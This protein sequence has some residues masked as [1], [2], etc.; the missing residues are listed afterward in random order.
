M[1]KINAIILIQLLCIFNFVLKAQTPNFYGL[2]TTGGGGNGSVFRT[3]TTGN[4]FELLDSFASADNGRRPF[5]TE[6]V[7][8]N[9]KLYGTITSGGNNQSGVLFEYNPTSNS[10]NVKFHFGTTNGVNP[11]G[12]LMLASNGKIYG[13]TMSGGTADRGTLF[14]YTPGAS[15]ITVKY[16][17]QFA[18]EGRQPRGRMIESASGI[19]MGICEGGGILNGG[20]IYEYNLSTSTHTN[21][22]NFIATTGGNPQGGLMKANNGK[23]YGLTT[24][25]GTNGKG[26]LYEYEPTNATLTAKVH[27]AGI[28]GDVGTTNLKQLPNGKLYG[29]TIYGGV[30]SGSGYGNIFEYDIIKDSI[31]SK[32]YGYGDNVGRYPAGDL[33][34]TSSGTYL[35]LMSGGGAF[36]YGGTVAEYNSTTNAFSAKVNFKRVE[37]GSNPDGNLV[38]FSGNGKYYGMCGYGGKG[39][40]GTIYEYDHATAKITNKVDLTPYPKGKQPSKSLVL[41]NNGKLYGTTEFGGDGYGTIF[42]V[43]PSNGKITNVANFNGVNGN[44]VRGTM[45]LA[46]N[47][48]LYGV[49]YSGGST[50]QGVLFQFNPTNNT[51]TKLKD[52]KDILTYYPQGGL[53]LATNG[54]L[55]GT[56]LSGGTKNYG[57]LFEYDIANGTLTKKADFDAAVTGNSPYA[58][59]LQANNGI[60]YGTCFEGGNNGKGTIYSYNINTNTLAT[61]AHFGANAAERPRGG[62]VQAPNGK[63]YGMST[64]WNSNNGTIYEFDAVGNNIA[65]KLDLVKSLHGYGGYGELLIGGNGKV[66]GMSAYSQYGPAQILEYDYIKDTTIVKGGVGGNVEGNLVQ[67]K[68]TNLSSLRAISQKNRSIM[69]PNPAKDIIQVSSLETIDM[70]S[71]YSLGGKQLIQTNLNT[72][73][74]SKLSSGVY[75]V[76]VKTASATNSSKL[77]IE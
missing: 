37:T 10:Y 7:E 39:E 64:Y 65:V 42:E 55:Y 13:T 31:S 60:L 71:I 26:T 59:M 12:H 3:D 21:K 69:Y 25:S 62:L 16:N 6:M 70:I 72:V 67:A 22:A 49:T 30:S 53:V 58:K 33:V 34:E 47:G 43:N 57:A 11:A 4:N 28:N 68:S 5:P 2:T 41:G 9:G 74:V 19:L 24:N 50:D 27:F 32:K 66:Y 15:S 76:I 77:L 61:L 75:I 46:P 35:L 73:D 48:L 38:K 54:K 52:I 40:N 45:V 36:D 51:I 44:R 23:I 20:T 14:E 17:F 56:T 1:K 8:A 18:A 63:F 29:S